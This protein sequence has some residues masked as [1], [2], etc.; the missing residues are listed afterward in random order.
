MVP[1]KKRLQQEAYLDVLKLLGKLCHLGIQTRTSESS[2][3]TSSGFA[4]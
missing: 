4:I 3:S 1:K 2:F